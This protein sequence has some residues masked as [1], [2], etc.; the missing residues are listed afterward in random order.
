VVT[1]ACVGLDDLFLDL[2]SG[3]KYY[4]QVVEQE[5]EK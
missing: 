5:S 4:D 1:L 3:Q 2:P